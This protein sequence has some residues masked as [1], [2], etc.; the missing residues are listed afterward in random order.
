MILGELITVEKTTY[1]EDANLQSATY[2]D[3]LIPT[4]VE[5]TDIEVTETTEL[6]TE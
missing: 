3:Y 2:M 4:A 1:D 5:V 6:M